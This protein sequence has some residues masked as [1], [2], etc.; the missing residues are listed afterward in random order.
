MKQ[1]IPIEQTAVER[2]IKRPNI[3]VMANVRVKDGA[4]LG[5]QGPA[6]L[7]YL[8]MASDL[9]TSM[10]VFSPAD[11]DISKSVLYGYVLT[12]GDTDGSYRLRRVLQQIPLVIYDQV[13]SRRYERIPNVADTLHFLRRK[14]VIF[15]DGYFDKWEVQSWLQSN[16]L[17][18][19]HLPHTAFL[20]NAK[21]LERFVSLYEVVFVKPIHGS[22]GI[23]ISKITRVPD[24]FEVVTRLKVGSSPVAKYATAGQ[25]YAAFKKNWRS[26]ARVIQEGIDLLHYEGRPL[27]LRAIVQKD[28][29]GTWKR[30]KVFGRVAGVGEF[31]SNLTTGGEAMSLS[32]LANDMPNLPWSDIRLQIQKLISVIPTVI[33]EGSGKLLGEMGIDLGMDISGHVHII[34]VNAKPWKTAAT[35]NGSAKLVDLSFM[36]PIRFAL[37]LARSFDA[38]GER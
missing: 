36:R 15:N 14:A 11:V 3:G 30:T 17:L 8:Q 7:K 33:E 10:C 2:Q 34:E 37:Q 18:R 13:L 20:M 4:F 28:G 25:L 23:G 38:G 35:E 1:E 32:A 5:K 26:K 19:K 22:L 16:P 6:L 29:S 27:D 9:K 31:T 24:G 21:T 12:P